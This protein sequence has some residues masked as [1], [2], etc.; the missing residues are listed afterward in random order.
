VFGI[1][2]GTNV[3][4]SHVTIENGSSFVG[5]GIDN[6]GTLTVTNSTL[7]GNSAVDSGG[8]IFNEPFSTL[9]VTNSTLLGNSTANADTFGGG[10]GFTNGSA[11]LKG[12][13]LA[14]N[15]NGNC[16]EQG[17]NLVT[18][19][20]YNLSDDATCASAFAQT[21]DK[22]STPAGLDPKGRLAISAPSSWSKLCSCPPSAHAW[23]S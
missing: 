16:Y 1:C 20:G 18:S 6:N 14:G 11:T 3:T 21:G 9:T 4:I 2:L 23:Q 8:G 10:I 19:A 12:T 17:T 13:L 5:A 22:N 15:S 7:S